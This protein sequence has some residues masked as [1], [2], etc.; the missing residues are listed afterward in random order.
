MPRPPTLL[1]LL[2]SLY[3]RASFPAR[4]NVWRLRLRRPIAERGDHHRRPGTGSGMTLLRAMTVTGEEVDHVDH[5]TSRRIWRVMHASLCRPNMMVVHTE[6]IGKLT[7]LSLMRAVAVEVRVTS[8]HSACPRPPAHVHSRRRVVKQL[9]PHRVCV[10][11]LAVPKTGLAAR[12][13]WLDHNII[14]VQ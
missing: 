3:G 5:V 10:A 4:R 13:P 7:L 9:Q 2:Q 11:R 6:V 8:H 14:S 1:L 12:G